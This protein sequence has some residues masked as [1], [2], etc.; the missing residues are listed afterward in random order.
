MKVRVFSKKFV[1]QNEDQGAAYI[2]NWQNRLE[3]RTQ[4]LKSGC[5]ELCIRKAGKSLFQVELCGFLR[6]TSSVT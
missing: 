6:N 2:I 1:Q 5:D 4:I 3:T